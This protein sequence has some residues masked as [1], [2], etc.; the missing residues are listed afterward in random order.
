MKKYLVTFKE[1]YTYTKEVEVEDNEDIDE[2]IHEPLYF[3]MV[4]HMTNEQYNNLNADVCNEYTITDK[5]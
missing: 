2:V 5:S 4:A 1:T 3:P